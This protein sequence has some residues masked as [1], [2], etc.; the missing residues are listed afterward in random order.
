MC[1]LDNHRR[2]PSK[3]IGCAMWILILREAA[4]IPNEPNQN[5]KPNYQTRKWI[6][7]HKKLRVDTYEN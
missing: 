1:H 3:I 6:R 7:I 5:Q 2:F 4:K